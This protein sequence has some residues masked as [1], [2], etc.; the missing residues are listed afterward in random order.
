MSHYTP[1][2]YFP[3]IL[4]WI[5]CNNINVKNIDFFNNIK[6]FLVEITFYSF[7]STP[8]FWW[9]W[10]ET[11]VS[12]TV[13]SFRCKSSTQYYH[14]CS[15]MWKIHLKHIHLCR[16]LVCVLI[17]ALMELLCLLDWVLQG[18]KNIYLQH[19]R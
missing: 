4:W 14:K 6:C 12:I 13:H 8:D 19:S 17:S 18:K 5:F 3:N 7:F 10:S 11:F 2:I 16:T 9:V 1:E 15:V